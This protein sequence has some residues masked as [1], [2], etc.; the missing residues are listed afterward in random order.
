M[1]SKYY[2]T[3]GCSTELDLIRLHKYVS[4]LSQ[5]AIL[6]VIINLS[7]C[8]LINQFKKIKK[9]IILLV[10]KDFYVNK[11]LR[12]KIKT[13]SYVENGEVALDQEP[14]NVI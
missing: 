13:K 9:V 4:C 12:K 5:A 7:T 1:R 3:V 6:L 14:V 8:V 10:K 2:K 11:I